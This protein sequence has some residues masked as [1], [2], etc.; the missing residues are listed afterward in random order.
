ME[1]YEL[2]NGKKFCLEIHDSGT[3]KVTREDEPDAGLVGIPEYYGTYA[4][5]RRYIE[6]Q[7]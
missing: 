7:R 6:K 4:E 1:K 5:C 3:Y 2:A